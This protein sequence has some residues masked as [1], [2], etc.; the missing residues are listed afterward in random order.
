MSHSP[1]QH[2]LCPT[3]SGGLRIACVGLGLL[4]LGIFP[5][6]LWAGK[7]HFEVISA[8]SRLDESSDPARWLVDARA[9]LELSSEALH[10]LESGV[11]L[12]I[13]FQYEVAKRRRF[14]PDEVRQTRRQHFELQ[15]LSLSQRY[16]VRDLSNATVNSYATLFSALRYLGKIRDFYLIDDWLGKRTKRY[17]FSMRVVLDWQKLPG[18][19]AV[20]AFWR[21]D[22][23]LKSNWYRWLPKR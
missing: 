6:P 5:T 8:S 9:D 23:S 21:G 22:F 10:A 17:A 12:R 20:L 11:V 7:G 13:S 2:F 15:Y 14:W 1:P 18:P 16:V 3:A 4:L 19:L